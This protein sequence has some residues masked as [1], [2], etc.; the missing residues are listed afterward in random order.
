M[1]E[2]SFTQADDGKTTALARGTHF[3]VVLPENGSTGYRW[4]VDHVDT[5]IVAER[6][7]QFSAGRSIAPGATGERQFAF[8]AKQVGATELI[9]GL[10][11]PWDPDGVPDQRFSLSVRVT[12]SN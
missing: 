7:S 11:Q 2:L 10:R 6:G 3:L 1:T 4:S 9:L 12:G 5:A 8:E